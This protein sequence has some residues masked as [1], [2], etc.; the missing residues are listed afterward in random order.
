MAVSKVAV[1]N[2]ALGEIGARRIAS[3]SDDTPEGRIISAFYDD[4]RDEVL[5][6]HPWTFAQKR[7]MLVA[8][9]A[10]PAFTNDFITIVY[11]KPSDLIKINFLN[12]PNANVKIE[13]QQILS[14]TTSLGIIYTWRNDDP[15]TY[16]QK[17]TMALAKKLA[18]TICFP[19]TQSA[20]KAQYLLTEYH[21][22]TLPSAVSLDSQQGTPL[23]ADA[24]EWESG[25]FIGGNSYVA[26]PGAQTWGYTW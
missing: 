14:D 3:F 17:F 24:S 20:T 26:Q 16:F 23:Q 15:T 6:E 22:L 1:A 11:A 18:A 7:V 10:T 4:I 12:Q 25:R 5:S 2:L 21:E 8:L 13:S 19:L 9:A